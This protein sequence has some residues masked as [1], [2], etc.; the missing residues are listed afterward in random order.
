MI[1]LAA[2]KIILAVLREITI[3]RLAILLPSRPTLNS[4]KDHKPPWPCCKNSPDINSCDVNVLLL[5]WPN[6]NNPP[7]GQAKWVTRPKGYLVT[8]QTNHCLKGLL[9][10]PMRTLL[11]K[12]APYKSIK[13]FFFLCS[14]SLLWPACWEGS[15]QQ[16]GSSKILMHFAAMAAVSVFFVS[17]G[18]LTNYNNI[19]TYCKHYTKLEKWRTFLLKSER[20]KNYHFVLT[21]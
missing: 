18:L 6:H 16:V 13:N 11:L 21:I 17:K 15:P 9:A 14:G 3:T 12:S 5:C 7:R 2:T 19:K 8:I 10:T 4:D 20:S 1:N